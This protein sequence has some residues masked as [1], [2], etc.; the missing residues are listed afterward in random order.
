[1]LIHSIAE[2]LDN[3]VKLLFVATTAIGTLFLIKDNTVRHETMNYF[4]GHEPLWHKFLEDNKKVLFQTY[5][6]DIERRTENEINNLKEDFFNSIV[7]DEE[8]ELYNY[9]HLDY[10]D[11]MIYPSWKQKGYGENNDIIDETAI[12]IV[13]HNTSFAAMQNSRKWSELCA[14]IRSDLARN[15]KGYKLWE[16]TIVILETCTGAFALLGWMTV[17]FSPMLSVLPGVNFNLMSIVSSLVSRIPI[18]GYILMATTSFMA[19]MPIVGDMLQ[20]IATVTP[21]TLLPGAINNALISKLVGQFTDKQYNLMTLIWEKKL[22]TVSK[23]DLFFAGF[24]TLAT[25]TSLGS[26]VL[27]NP[28]TAHPICMYGIAGITTLGALLNITNAFNHGVAEKIVGIT[29]DP[30]STFTYSIGMFALLSIATSSMLPTT[31]SVVFSAI[32]VSISAF[33]LSDAKTKEKMQEGIT[34]SLVVFEAIAL[35]AALYNYTKISEIPF[36]LNLTSVGAN[37]LQLILDHIKSVAMTT[38]L[39]SI[40]ASAVIAYKYIDYSVYSHGLSAVLGKGSTVIDYL[41]DIKSN[42]FSSSDNTLEFKSVEGVSVPIQLPNVQFGIGASGL[43]SFN[44]QQKE[45]DISYL[46]EWPARFGYATLMVPT[47]FMTAI[48]M[49]CAMAAIANTSLLG[50]VLTGFTI[51]SATMLVEKVYLYQQGKVHLLLTKQELLKT[52]VF[53]AALFLSPA[54]ASYFVNVVDLLLPGI[55]TS[56]AITGALV[57]VQSMYLPQFDGKITVASLGLSA[58]AT[59]LTTLFAYR[60][61]VGNVIGLVVFPAAALGI[62]NLAVTG[63]K[64]LAWENDYVQNINNLLDALLNDEK[65]QLIANTIVR[66]RDNVNQNAEWTIQQTVGLQQAISQVYCLNLNTLKQNMPLY[67]LLGDPRVNYTEEQIQS[68]LTQI[69]E[70]MVGYYTANP[71]QDQESRQDLELR[72]N[73]VFAEYQALDRGNNQRG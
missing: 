35:M 1:M 39:M 42:I 20:G 50:A 4:M 3:K 5:G 19:K 73:D 51:L 43:P 12:I 9:N 36:P 22:A 2:I 26:V 56:I 27:N 63:T 55:T 16:D 64:R 66:I 17:N 25:M 59:I 28:I 53:T 68:K 47:V 11:C 15:D 69:Q 10:F 13:R 41:L 38:V 57:G 62:Y 58:C 23:V 45:I 14:L 21:L 31:L 24:S 49:Y 65:Q 71:Q 61:N 72:V 67:Q 32:F 34:R 40:G 7:H 33:K 46:K 8:R 44:M 70:L 52:A 37:A 29:S 54:F 48:G 30:F 60:Y 6:K 18:L